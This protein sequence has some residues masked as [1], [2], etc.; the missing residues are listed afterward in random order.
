MHYRSTRSAARPVTVS[1]AVE[2]G[3]APDGG[4]YVP[5]SFPRFRVDDFTGVEDV[6]AIAERLL[7]PF[8]DADPLR[9]RLGA[10][11]RDAFDFPIPLRALPRRTAMLELFHGPTAAFKDVGARLL[12]GCFDALAEQTRSREAAPCTVLVATSGDTGAAIASA[13]HDRAGFEVVIL[14]PQGGVSARQQ[15]LLTCWEGNVRA[16]AVRGVFDDCQR[17]VKEAFADEAWRRGRRL[18][19]ANSINIG[20]LLPQLVYH[21]AASLRYEREHGCAPSL[22]VPTGN[23]G[24]ACAALWAKQIG[25]PI[26]RVVMSVNANRTVPDY[27]RTAQWSPR[28]SVATLANAMD[29]G[30]PSNMERVLD[31]YPDVESLR[32]VADAESVGDDVIRRT[33]VAGPERWGV[34]FCPHTATAF[35]Y[36]ETHPDGHAIVVATAHPAK[37]DPIEGFAA[38]MPD[39]LARLLDRPARCVEIDASLG[40]LAAALESAAG[41]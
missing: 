41:Q 32:E 3:L 26:A 15:H 1:T 38:P 37:F 31:L 6:A 14:F 13:F 10:I 18:T 17:I 5:E 8:F 27:L 30:S 2:H 22:I 28:P 12:A 23:V 40:A 34:P 19:S 7:E 39:A 9:P 36:R 16:F 35:H 24:N 4:L 11:C 20:R 21:A 33:I 25:L 29:V